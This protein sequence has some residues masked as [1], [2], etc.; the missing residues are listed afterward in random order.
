MSFQS[1]LTC[2]F[3]GT[4]AQD[5]AKNPPVQ[6]IVAPYLCLFEMQ[7]THLQNASK[8]KFQKFY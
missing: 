4:Q 1:I 8:H 3:C 5:M 6:L 7:I 2:L